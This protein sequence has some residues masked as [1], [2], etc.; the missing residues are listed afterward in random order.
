[1]VRGRE[2][3]AA[4]QGLHAG[5]GKATPGHWLVV[6][7]SKFGAGRGGAPVRRG[8]WSPA[9]GH[10]LPPAPRPGFGLCS[11]SGGSVRRG[12][13]E[14]PERSPP[15]GRR[16]WRAVPS[17]QPVGAEA[18]GLRRAARGR[19]GQEAT[20][21]AGRRF[22]PVGWV[23]ASS[24]CR[25]EAEPGE[26]GALRAAGWAPA[27]PPSPAPLLTCWAPGGGGAVPSCGWLGSAILQSLFSSF[28][29]FSSS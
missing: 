13:A 15:G 28:I 7:L 26:E 8:C 25:G 10:C 11:C 23:L 21:P 24:P 22:Q 16:G 18:A 14:G 6:W 20:S 12:P 2:G 29:A 5:A 1:M 9:G 27:C 3:V 4:G 17:C 19:D